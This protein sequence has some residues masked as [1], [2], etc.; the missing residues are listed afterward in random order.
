MRAFKIFSLI[1]LFISNFSLSQTKE[2]IVYTSGNYISSLAEEGNYLWVGT[3][4]GGLVKLDKTTGEFIVYDKLNSGLP[5]NDVYGIAVDGQGNKWIGTY[6]GG[7]AL[8]LENKDKSIA[9]GDKKVEKID[10]PQNN[11]ILLGR[12]ERE[13][14]EPLFTYQNGTFNGASIVDENPDVDKSILTQFEKLHLYS[15]YGD[16]LGKIDV[17]EL[18][19]IEVGCVK[20]VVGKFKNTKPKDYGY[21]L[22]LPIPQKNFYKG[23]KFSRNDTI[24]SL[25][26][27]LSIVNDF[28]SSNSL[29]LKIKSF[30]IQRLVKFD[31]NSDGEFE[32]FAKI[33]AKPQNEDEDCFIMTSFI[34]SSNKI[35][36]SSITYI[37]SDG[38]PEAG[39]DYTIDF[40]FACDIDADSIAEI[41]VIV[42]YY[43]SYAYQILKFYKNKF[44]KVATTSGGGC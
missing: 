10:L 28:I 31:A 2:W 17:N 32:I 7:L 39:D 26:L 1:L 35:A 36:F 43:E 12:F 40:E 8:Y 44:I 13:I 22:N 37:N 33:K 27:A 14:L 3:R 5:D 20:K 9:T 42:G 34:I 29:N 25:N 23:A 4:G 6:G 41:V 11:L 21:F 38:S 30:E 16:Y 24:L 15:N 18:T 19:T